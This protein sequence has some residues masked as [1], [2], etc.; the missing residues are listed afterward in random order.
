MMELAAMG[1][2][3]FLTLAGCREDKKGAKT[4]EGISVD[5]H[6][7]DVAGW[8]GD[9][10][11]IM[12]ANRLFEFLGGRD[13]WARLSALYIH[14]Q[15]E[16]DSFGAYPS[17]QFQSMEED[18][19]IVDQ[20]INDMRFIRILDDDLAWTIS[21]G[22]IAEMDETNRQF[23]VYW[24][25]LDYYRN[26]HQLAAGTGLRVLF[27]NEFRLFIMREEEF[28]FAL[29][30]DEQYRP[31]IFQ[32]PEFNDQNISLRLMEWSQ[33]EGFVYPSSGSAVEGDFE[34]TVLEFVP[35]YENAEDAFEV[36]FNPEYVDVVLEH[37]LK[38]F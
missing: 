2:M 33:T 16:D 38:P 11:S 4:M 19:I 29:Q 20:Y 31:V 21:D 22:D 27:T 13:R 32:R 25:H 30:L 3:V 9:D 26:I 5:S 18:R 8:E 28:V 7:A 35:G 37:G 36:P 17:I 34:F 14:Y 23:L 15:Q 1:F 12:A 6:H 10:R 24:L